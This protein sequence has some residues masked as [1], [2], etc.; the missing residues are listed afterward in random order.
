[1]SIKQI[2]HKLLTAKEE[3][4]LAA[5]IATGDMFARESMINHNLR[6]AISIANQYR[7]SGLDMEDISQ[8]ANI[9]LIKAV[10]RFDHT[11]GFRFSTYACWWIKQSIRR[12]ISSQGSHVKFPAGSRNTIYK[13]NKL[14]SEYEN[15]FGVLPDDIEVAELMGMKPEKV[16]NL[17]IGMQWPININRPIGGE[18]GNR[19]YA[20]IIPDETPLPDEAMDNKLLIQQIKSS[21]SSLTPQEERILRLRFG[22]SEDESSIE[23]IEYKT[24]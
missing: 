2:R 21:L 17:R 14:R 13:I 6:L 19:T 18:E 12:Y 10:D 11:K 20:D 5:K 16:T 4:D 7:R 23:F 22:I 1:L 3:R 15:E 9:G 24:I 8:E